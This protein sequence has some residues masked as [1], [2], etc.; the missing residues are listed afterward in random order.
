MWIK[1]LGLVGLALAAGL[2]TAACNDGYGYGGLSAGYGAGYGG[3]GGYGDGF[4]DAGYGGYGYAPSYFGWYGDYYYPGTGVYVY[5]R[6]RRPYRWNGAQQRYWQG[7]RGSYGNAQVRNNWA[8]FRQDVRNE[9]RDYRGDL[10]T[11]RQAFQSGTITREQFQQ[12]RRDARREYRRDVRQDYRELRQ[13]NRAQGVTTPR[14]GMRSGAGLRAGGPRTGG[15][16][17]GGGRRGGAPRAGN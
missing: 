2:S 17:F 1:R 12:G 5:D 7:R 11:N 14:Y 6:Y 16:R 8:D 3:Y 13:A 15:P 9:R 4:Y 10:R